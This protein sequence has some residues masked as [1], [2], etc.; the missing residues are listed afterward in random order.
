MDGRN[1]NT[2]LI[3][4]IASSSAAAT[5]SM[6]NSNTITILTI[7][8]IIVVIVSI[9]ILLFPMMPNPTRL[10]L[11]ACLIWMNDRWIIVKSNLSES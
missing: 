6:A 11:I 1:A 8:I 3:T 2:E 4:H 10:T 5:T 7:L 9:G